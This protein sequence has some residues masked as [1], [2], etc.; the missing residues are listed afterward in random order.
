MEERRIYRGQ[1]QKY[2]KCLFVP[3]ALRGY[4]PKKYP[5]SDMDC[6]NECLYISKV[7]K[8]LQDLKIDTDG[9]K[10]KCEKILKEEPFKDCDDG[11]PYVFWLSIVFCGIKI[12][13]RG[14]NTSFSGNGCIP[15]PINMGKGF[16][17]RDN[18]DVVFKIDCARTVEEYAVK[19][20][21]YYFEH[22]PPN[23]CDNFL[24]KSMIHQ[25]YCKDSFDYET[26][27]K[28]YRLDDGS[29]IDGNNLPDHF[30]LLLDWTKCECVAT[31]F[32][33]EDGT[34]ISI[35]S[36]KYDNLIGADYRMSY[37]DEVIKSCL[38]DTAEKQK[39]VVTFWPW[40][41]TIDELENNELGSILDFRVDVRAGKKT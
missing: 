14:K 4:W 36:E 5:F 41:F 11:I 27:E 40:T 24:R 38:I 18:G 22:N 1:L 6:C 8:F 7:E 20:V 2:D 21:R 16:D 34:I 26:W 29:I 33:G 15:Y 31:E 39:A 35:D 3:S 30:T 17:I 13:N 23:K 25:H 12:A 37:D 10:K 19:I 28:S 9:Y 32:A